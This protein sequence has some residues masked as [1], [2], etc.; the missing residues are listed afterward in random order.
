MLTTKLQRIK[1][2]IEQ[3]EKIDNELAQLLGETERP[4]RGR[5][6]KDKPKDGEPDS[7]PQA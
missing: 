1:E 3:K 6:K 5:P 2:L 4:P 7:A